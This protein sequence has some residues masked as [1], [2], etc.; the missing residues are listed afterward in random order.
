MSFESRMHREAKELVGS[1]IR[2]GPGY[3]NIA[4]DDG[5]RI[6]NWRLNTSGL[7]PI[8]ECS[9][10]NAAEIS[11]ADLY[12]AH[13]GHWPEMIFDVG[14]VRDGKV[15]AAFEIMKSHWIDDKKKKKIYRAGI[16]VIGV[17]AQS[18]QWYVSD[19]RIDARLLMIPRSYEH[20]I[21]PAWHGMT[22]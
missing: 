9:Y 8:I 1:M 20:I 3:I 11:D 17:P 6:S 14:L 21:E 16:I 5:V 7:E 12:F 19:D 18:N 15:L 13:H 10:P 22:V 2:N 4:C